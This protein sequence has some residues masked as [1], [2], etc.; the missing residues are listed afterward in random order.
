[1][2]GKRITS[3]ST[4]PHLSN[5]ICL[6][7][8]KCLQCRPDLLRCN[9]NSVFLMYL[10]H[11]NVKTSIKTSIIR[12]MAVKP[13]ENP[14][15]QTKPK[16]NPKMSLHRPKNP[17]FQ[18]FCNGSTTLGAKYVQNF[19]NFGFLGRCND[20][21]GFCLGFVWVFGFSFGFTAMCHAMLVKQ[22]KSANFHKCSRYVTGEC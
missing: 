4:L 14:K 21:F 13:M 2:T 15:T 19:E 16:K 1:M 18:G 20:F 6:H 11:S 12:H 10:A 17:K 5:P 7:A 3:S 9:P 22:R 8:P